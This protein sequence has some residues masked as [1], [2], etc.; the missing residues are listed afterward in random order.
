MVYYY[1]DQL[2]RPQHEALNSLT[3]LRRKIEDS[4]RS[5]DGNYQ[6]WQEEAT[7]TIPLAMTYREGRRTTDTGNIREI[8]RICE[9]LNL[10]AIV[11]RVRALERLAHKQ[12]VK[13]ELQDLKYRVQNTLTNRF[14]HGKALGRKVKGFAK[15]LWLACFA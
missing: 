1:G 9:L 13:D 3:C 2:F 11:D 15:H 10:D 14:N 8:I 7:K 12:I 6:A 4:I 5:R